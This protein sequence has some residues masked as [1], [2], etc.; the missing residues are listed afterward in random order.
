[1]NNHDDP[2]WLREQY[3]KKGL[4]VRDIAGK[5]DVGRSTIRRRMDKFNIERR[6]RHSTDHQY[7]ANELRRLYY[8]AEYSTVDLADHYG[9]AERTVARW[10]DKEGMPRR[11]SSR[12]Q[13]HAC[14]YTTQNGYE[15]WATLT[16]KKHH[17]FRVSRL[18]A[19]AEYGF[20]AV[21]G[22]D[23]H[24][25]NHIPWDNRPENIEVLSPEEHGLYHARERWDKVERSV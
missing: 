10:M 9:M 22:K 3:H 12:E 4:T 14:F 16:S 19:V 1:M 21:A 11:P 20:E 13:T 18:L 8:E 23:V 2:Q 17:C 15:E 6:S 25:K 7:N 24:H 5:T